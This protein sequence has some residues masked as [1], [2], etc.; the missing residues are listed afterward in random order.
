MLFRSPWAISQRSRAASIEIKIAVNKTVP[1]R[2]TFNASGESN[3]RMPFAQSHK[4]NA[5]INGISTKKNPK[6]F[7]GVVRLSFGDSSLLIG[8]GIGGIEPFS[9]LTVP[10]WE[11]GSQ[12]SH[13]SC[14][15]KS[16]IVTAPKEIGRAHV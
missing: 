11:I 3:V 14:Q 8:C 15:Y 1:I 9:R 4:V 2:I 7:E 5:E 16:V 12:F 13:P 6:A 10:N